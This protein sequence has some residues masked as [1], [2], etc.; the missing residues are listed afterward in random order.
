MRSFEITETVE[1]SR[2]I[3]KLANA[4][5]KW[6]YQH[7]PA[8]YPSQT[9][10]KMTGIKDTVLSKLK[11]T[12]DY[13]EKD[14]VAEYHR[15]HESKPLIVVNLDEWQEGDYASIAEYVAHELRHALDDIKFKGKHQ[16]SYWA[17]QDRYQ[18]PKNKE[19]PYWSKPSEINA[20]VQ[21][22]LHNVDYIKRDNPG[23][24]IKELWPEIKDMLDELKL[25]EYPGYQRIVKR[26]LAYAEKN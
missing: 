25:T 7:E 10:A 24:S 16:I 17:G 8:E 4:I 21:Q 12:F 5:S 22:A 18:Q 19:E 14:T 11:I 26:I 1:D 13:L 15:E 9:I 23:V 20:R 6:M 2:L 3:N